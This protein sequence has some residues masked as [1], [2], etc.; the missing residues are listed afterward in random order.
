MTQF[1]VAMILFKRVYEECDEN[2]FPG[3]K[4]AWLY[5]YKNTV[6]AWHYKMLAH[7]MEWLSCAVHVVGRSQVYNEG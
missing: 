5:E 3:M 1:K 4:V 6:R 7:V 2:F